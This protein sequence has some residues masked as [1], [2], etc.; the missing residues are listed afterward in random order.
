MTIILNSFVSNAQTTDS[1]NKIHYFK[2]KI[3]GQDKKPIAFAHV[4]NVHRNYATISNAEGI[5]S[6]PAII[7]D[8]L[9]I[10]AIGFYTK[11]LP[12]KNIESDST[13]H[14]LTLISRE[15]NLP[16]VNIYELRWQ[17]FK[18]EFMEAESEEVATAQKIS[19]WMAKLVSPEELKLIQQSTMKPGFVIDFTGKRRKSERKV[20]RM[21][22]KFQIIAPK[23]N[24][25]LITKLTGLKGKEIYPFLRYCNFSEDFLINAS[26]YEI[27]EQI[28]KFWKEYKD[29]NKRKKTLK[30]DN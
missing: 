17:V 26:E 1:I 13:K 28:L 3:I 8:T 21:E 4:I 16:T 24:D 5:F 20:A 6:I 19:D 22:K 10:S 15:Y 18:S 11:Y 27:M 12:I 25:K 9:R 7:G 30:P 2:G 29:K 23:F 14:V